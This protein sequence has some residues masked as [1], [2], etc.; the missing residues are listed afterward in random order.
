MKKLFN[1]AVKAI[2][3]KADVH[4]EAV[5]A[6][7]HYFFGGGKDRTLP[8]EYHQETKEALLEYLDIITHYS[9]WSRVGHIRIGKAPWDGAWYSDLSG[10]IGAF[11]FD[12]EVDEESGK[13]IAHCRD[14]WNFNIVPEEHKDEDF[15]DFIE[16]PSTPLDKLIVAAAKM[17]GVAVSLI[18]K[19]GET[20][21]AVSEQE[22]ATLNKGR[23]YYTRWDI[24]VPFEEIHFINVKDHDWKHGGLPK[25][26]IKEQAR[27]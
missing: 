4:P 15:E 11:N 9:A 1:A 25:A 20:F 7:Y 8:E 22:L 21:L 3:A 19:D 13:L 26:W 16:I 6:V 17:M 27:S 23:E 24:E 10:V 12:F 5:N 14:K 2:A 18:Q